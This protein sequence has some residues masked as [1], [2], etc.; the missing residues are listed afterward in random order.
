M[1]TG[2]RTQR[3]SFLLLQ[4]S[5]W[6]VPPYHACFYFCAI[7]FLHCSTLRNPSIFYHGKPNAEHPC[8]ATTLMDL[9]CAK[10][11]GN[12]VPVGHISLQKIESVSNQYMNSVHRN[13]KTALTAVCGSEY[14]NSWIIVPIICL[15]VEKRLA[16]EADR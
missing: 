5:K 1:W 11:H 2:I 10:S 4:A 9:A 8:S 7:S 6:H 3:P 14:W 12:E 13:A 15:N 16:L